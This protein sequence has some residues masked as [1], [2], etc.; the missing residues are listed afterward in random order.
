MGQRNPVWALPSLL[1]A[2]VRRIRLELLD[3]DGAATHRRIRLYAEALA[4]RMATQDVWSQ[5]GSTTSSASP[6]AA[7]A[8]G[9]GAHQSILTLR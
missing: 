2:G 3:E 6:A 1:R 5:G 9:S 7:C 4:G 8:A